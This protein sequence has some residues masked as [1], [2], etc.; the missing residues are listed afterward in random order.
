M[1][2]ADHDVAQLGRK[3]LAVRKELADLNTVIVR[4]GIIMFVVMA[5]IK[6]LS[7]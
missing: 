1:M 3:M 4:V 6:L 5:I 2:L 7:L